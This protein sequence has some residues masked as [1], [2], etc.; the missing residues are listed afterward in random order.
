MI[1]ITEGMCLV[2]SHRHECSVIRSCDDVVFDVC[3]DAV[4][5]R[6]RQGIVTDGNQVFCTLC[7]AHYFE[8]PQCLRQQT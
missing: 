1:D 3:V 7:Q 8:P 5:G 6:P 2:E 4:A